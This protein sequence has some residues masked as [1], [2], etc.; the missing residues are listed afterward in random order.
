MAENK[1]PQILK[2]QIEEVDKAY[3]QAIT[4]ERDFILTEMSEEEFIDE[5]V[6]I[7]NKDNPGEPIIK[8]IMW[9]GQRTA[10]REIADNRLNIILKARQLGFT[11]L[12]LAM[13]IL[14]VLRYPGYRVIVLS[15]T[16][17]K[18]KELINRCEL[19]LS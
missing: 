6:Y 9:E 11:W 18:S 13:F 2:K 8:F 4:L 5:Y 1:D 15:E 16:E 19:I 3:Y 7:E 14:Y 10:L 17:E 12:C